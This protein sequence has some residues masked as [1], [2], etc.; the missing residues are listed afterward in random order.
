M[1]LERTLAWNWL[2]WTLVGV[3]LLSAFTAFLKG[4]IRELIS[5]AALVAGLVV[6]AVGYQRASAWFEDLTRSHQIAE[7]VAF[8]VLLLGVLLAGGLVSALAGR[9][10]KTAG[11]QRIDRLLGA[12]FGLIRG[13]ALDSILL[14]ALV[15]FGMK[16]G[17]VRQSV[18]ARSLTGWAETLAEAMPD[19]LR[20]EF[21]AGL[22]KLKQTMG[23]TDKKT[24]SGKNTRD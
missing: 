2:D 1:G 18:L 7:G 5:L 6:A 10:I 15:A 3:V 16:T 21:R 14:L 11:L 4:F 20:T 23:E 9:L 19:P 24:E 22:Q 12:C 13:L 17:A 8:L